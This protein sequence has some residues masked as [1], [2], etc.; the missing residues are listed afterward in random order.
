MGCLNRLYSLSLTHHDINFLYAIQGSLEHGY[1]FQTLNTT[2]RLIS[3]LL[4]SNKNSTGEYVRN[5]LNREMTCWTSPYQIGRYFFYRSLCIHQLSLP[6]PFSFFI[7]ILLTCSLLFAFH[8][9]HYFFY[10]SLTFTI[11]PTE[12]SKKF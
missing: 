12:V 8:P 1:Y 11:F 4:D 2:V 7:F 9:V 5:W 6:F 3:C 10:L